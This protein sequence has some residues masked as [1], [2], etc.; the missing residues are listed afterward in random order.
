[1]RPFALGA[2]AYLWILN[3]L[4]V[5][6]RGRLH[7]PDQWSDVYML[8]LGTYAGA[9]EIKRWNTGEVTDPETWPEQVRKGGPIVTAWILLLFGVGAWRLFDPSR[10]MPT[11]LKEIT[12]KVIGVFFGVYALR[13]VRKSR[14]R[15]AVDSSDPVADNA[16]T[17]RILEHLRAN[18]PKTPAA[19]SDALNIPRRSLSRLLKALVESGRLTRDGGAFDPNATYRST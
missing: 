12:M 3:L 2:T 11:E 8:I 5:I 17:Q 18:G 13:Q 14:A 4:E 19:I 1:M 10:L 9:G 15:S 16:D 6:T 7:S